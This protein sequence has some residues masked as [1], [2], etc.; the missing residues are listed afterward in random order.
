MHSGSPL[1]RLLLVLP[2]LWLVASA[3]LAAEDTKVY[4]QA[5]AAAEAPLSPPQLDQLLGPIALYPDAVVAIVLPASTFPADVVLAARY[6][7][8]GGDS[9]KT[10]GQPWDDSVKSLARFPEVVKWMDENLHWTKQLGEAFIRQPADVMNAIQRL[11]AAARATG[12]LVTTPE[13]QVV[14]DGDTIEILPVQPDVIYVPRYDP[15]V[16]YISHP[17]GYAYP[18]G[19]YLTFGAGF[20]MGF[21]LAY[22][23]DWFNHEIWVGN[24]SHDWREH[25]DWRRSMPARTP[26]RPPDPNWRAWKPPANRP[27]P[28]PSRWHGEP[29]VERPRPF[30]GTPG[31]PNHPRPPRPPRR[32]DD[33]GHRS[34][35][36]SQPAPVDYSRATAPGT[37]NLNRATPPSIPT[38]N[39]ATP[40]PPTTRQ[41]PE[42]RAPP[43]ENY[44]SRP[45]P[46]PPPSRVQPPRPPASVPAASTMAPVAPRQMPSA[47][48]AAA[49]RSFSSPP[50]PPPPPPPAPA[51]SRDPDR[52]EKQN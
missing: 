8:D 29:R 24:H 44:G 26:Q 33:P 47:P 36:R 4:T 7:E 13:Q 1:R 42:H 49:S 3:P 18:Y 5:S 21:W 32:D 43:R 17:P 11:R 50:P 16:V 2:G 41:T 22:D 9:T 38:E 19:P 52:Q 37:S 35:P 23:F 14:V 48:P 30:P 45:P 39:R 46:S 6:L 34:G 31:A 10:D 51:R 20:T 27:P 12:A 15:T 40:V 25:R 28:P